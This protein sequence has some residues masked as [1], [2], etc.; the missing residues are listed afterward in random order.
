[1]VDTYISCASGEEPV[2]L[3]ENYWRRKVRL[4]KYGK[5]LRFI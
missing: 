1:M 4:V 5:V 2:K 3:L